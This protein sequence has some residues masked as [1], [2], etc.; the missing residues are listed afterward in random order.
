MCGIAG[1]VSLDP[2]GSVRGP[3]ESMVAVLRHRGPDDAGEYRHGAVAFGHRRLSIIDLSAAGHQPMANGDGSIRLIYNGEIY[4]YRELDAQLKARGYAYRSQSDTETIIHAYEEWGVDCVQRFNG[5]FAFALWDGRRRRVFCARDRFGEKPFYYVLQP[6]RLVF[7]SEIKAV[8]ADP[9]VPRDP[10]FQTIAAY[11]EHNLTDTNDSTFFAAVKSLKP[12]HTLIVEAGRVTSR[13]Y[14]QPPA[15]PLGAPPRSD[16]DWIAE[17]RDTFTNAVKL[18]LR[19][20]VPLGTCLSGGLDSSSIICVTSR[21]TAAPVSA[22]SVVY[23]E[24]EFAEAQ[25]VRHVSDAVP[26]DAHSVTPTGADL[27]ETLARIVHHNDEPSTSYGQY[28]QWHVMKLAAEHGVTV[29]LNGQGG[30]ELLAGYDRYLPTYVRELAL[31][32]HL[33]QVARELNVLGTPVQDSVKR[34]LYPLIA[35]SWREAYRTSVTRQWRPRDYLSADFADAFANGV[36]AA[37]ASTLRDHQLH[38][39]TVASLPALVHHEDR[40]SMAFSREIRLPF[41]DPRVVDLGVQM[42]PSLKIRNGVT[43]YVLR[44]AMA[45]GGVPPAILNRRDKK[46]YPTPVG[47]W[48]RTVAREQAWAVLAS[49]SFRER[50]IVDVEKARRAF[51]MHVSGAADF[52]LSI[53]QWVSLELWFRAFVDAAVSAGEPV[54][55]V[56]NAVPC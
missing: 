55:A 39:L 28:S 49:K 34:A 11:L 24:Q 13:C 44:Q 25:F 16:D 19:S 54:R 50:G 14:W 51:T 22:F 23:N 5:M 29:L 7:A 46:G 1:F 17:F 32:G 12:A 36:T 27:F 15:P 37:A 41:L 45:T 56:A 38:D 20:D 35:P 26:I 4:N 9:S 33:R 30:D 47:L 18:R 6:D 21:I 53:W 31:A 43:K 48:F 52:T 10:D 40:M 2:A 42:P 8:L 3:L